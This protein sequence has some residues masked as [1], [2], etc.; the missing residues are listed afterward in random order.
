MEIK[1]IIIGENI[2]TFVNNYGNT[3]NG[4]KH[5]S[6]LFKSSPTSTKYEIGR[7]TAHYLNRTWERYTYQSTMQGVVDSLI[8][9]LVSD[10]TEAYKRDNDIKR[11]TGKR[12]V[13][14]SEIVHANADY[15]EFTKLYEALK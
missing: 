1:E 15:I 2:Y 13:A 3:R 9:S 5:T 11:L 10:I 6:V 4:F 8:D 12:Q 7:Y 14:V